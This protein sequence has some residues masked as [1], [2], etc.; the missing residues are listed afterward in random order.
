MSKITNQD[1][2]KLVVQLIQRSK[3]EGSELDALIALRD[4]CIDVL[5]PVTPEDNSDAQS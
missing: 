2:A 1:A 3:F 4:W 5:Q